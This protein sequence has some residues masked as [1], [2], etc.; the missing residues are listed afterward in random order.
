MKLALI[1]TSSHGEKEL[2]LPLSLPPGEKDAQRQVRAN[3]ESWDE[4]S[5]FFAATSN[6]DS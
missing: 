1:L 5:P 2:P 4:G 6:L 3:G